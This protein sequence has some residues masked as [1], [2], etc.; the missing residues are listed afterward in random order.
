MMAGFVFSFPEMLMSR[1]IKRR[2]VSDS[3][4]T[5][6][7]EYNT[8]LSALPNELSPMLTWAKEHTPITI[9]K[10]ASKYLTMHSP[11]SISVLQY[12]IDIVIQNM[13]PIIKLKENF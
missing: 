8:L 10:Q 3:V 12:N 4:M 6:F 11:I 5:P 2:L 9:P 13:I 7:V 1:I